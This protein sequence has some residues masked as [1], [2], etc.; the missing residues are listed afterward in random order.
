[1][2]VALVHDWLTGMRGGERV[3]EVFLR[4]YP[5]ADLYT[6]FHLKGRVTPAIEAR[7]PRTTFLQNM[8]WLK[9][10]YRYYLP[11]FP[12]AVEQLP[13]YPYDL[14]IS[15]SHCVALGAL[16]GEEGCHIA[17]CFTPM[18]Y[19]AGPF[20]VVIGN[21]PGR[22]RRRLMEGCFHYLRLW[23]MSAARRP[24][25][26][27]AISHTVQRRLSKRL[28]ISS[29]LL[30]PPV[31]NV[32]LNAGV[33][34]DREDF[35]LVVSALVPYKRIDLA[36]EAFRRNG[37]RLVIIG[38]GPCRRELA[39]AAPPNVE[40]R[41][42]LPDAEVIRH[43]QRCRA[44]VFPGEEDFGLAPLE[45]Q[46]CGTP[47]IAFNRGG[48]R[49]VVH[50]EYG[51]FFDEPTAEALNEAVERQ[52]DQQ[53]DRAALH[54]FARQFREELFIERWRELVE[55]LSAQTRAVL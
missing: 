7:A 3:L 2:R 4:M 22:F 16:S 6:L 8:P 50:P 38:D 47:V 25:H 30:N 10:S 20:E 13:V 15:L 14:V 51:T 23:E 9:R 27:V 39:Q 31:S 53:C 37:R 12:L 28:N 33:S 40:I 26:L 5:E 32:F 34:D 18:R 36:V 55:R 1:M 17:Y 42:P 24:D 49:E 44:F 54:A 41:G 45:A 46:A 43:Y 11:F 52:A 21:S 19:L 35:Y 29:H 48:A